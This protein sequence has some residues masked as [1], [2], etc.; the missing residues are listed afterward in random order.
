[1]AKSIQLSRRS[2]IPVPGISSYKMIVEAINAQDMPDKIFIKQRIHNFAR[3]RFDDVFVAVC[4]PTQ[5]EDFAED[6][7]EDGT[8]FFRTNQIELV[9]RTPEWLQE[10]FESLVYETKKLVIDL[11]DLDNLTAAEVYLINAEDPVTLVD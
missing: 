11:T 4:T 8:S 10:V 3:E 5:L 7:P 1:M 6:S 9:G 2:T